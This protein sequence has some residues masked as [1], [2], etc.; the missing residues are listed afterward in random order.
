MARS[1]LE[2]QIERTAS[3]RPKGFTVLKDGKPLARTTPGMAGRGIR[4]DYTPNL[5]VQPR[6]SVED[7]DGVDEI[8]DAG[9]ELEA[10]PIPTK[11][12]KAPIVVKKPIITK[13]GDPSLA[14]RIQRGIQ[15]KLNRR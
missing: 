4:R 13:S 3:G 9:P 8:E 10:A 14:E 15:E 2:C 6:A 1:K 11:K 7:A 12:A 5:P